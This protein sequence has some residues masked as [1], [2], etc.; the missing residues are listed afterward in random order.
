MNRG[1]L[2][3]LKNSNHLHSSSLFRLNNV[4]VDFGKIRALK[5]VNLQISRGE[6]LFVTGKSGAGKSTLLNILSGD[7][8][9]SSGTVTLPSSKIFVSQVFQDLKLFENRT[10]EE[11]LWYAFDKKIY[12]SKNEF[13]KDLMELSS[14]L[15]IK[16]RLSHKIK[17]A[18]GGM[19]QK[20]AMLRA[21]LSKPEVLLADEPTA[22]LD[23]ESSTKMF[24]LLNFYNVRKGLTIVWATHNR[25]L[26]KQFPG[27]IAHLE[28]GKLIY[29]G[30][31][32]F[33]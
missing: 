6:V 8:E 7:V 13:Q 22:A 20:V 17:G 30:K 18:N 21:L 9:V 24:D 25:E 11:N 2:E 28:S 23:K 16:D 26:V 1:F 27:E 31:A 19:K 10:V 14:V 29:S 33:I 15:G 4:N 32:C 5:N 12:K 3:S